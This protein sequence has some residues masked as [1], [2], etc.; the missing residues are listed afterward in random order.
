M[1]AYVCLRI[2]MFTICVCVYIY[3][4]LMFIYDHL[5]SFSTHRLIGNIQKLWENVPVAKLIAILWVIKKLLDPITSHNTYQR[6]HD[7][8]LSHKNSWASLVSRNLDNNNNIKCRGAFYAYRFLFQIYATSI[9]GCQAFLAG[10][11]ILVTVSIT[12]PSSIHPKNCQSTNSPLKM[13]E[14]V[15]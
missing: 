6:T 13:W 7:P 4:Y 12:H 2:I 8:W 5:C 9:I 3:T 1:Y 15:T 11:Y 14:K 10:G